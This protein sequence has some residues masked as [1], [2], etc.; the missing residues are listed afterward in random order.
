MNRKSPRSV[1]VALVEVKPL[2]GCE[3]DPLLYGGAVVRCYVAAETEKEAVGSIAADLRDM[4]FELESLDWCVDDATVEWETPNDPTA[5]SLKSEAR[6]SEEV[7]F[8]E[9]HAWPLEE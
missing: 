5:A 7:I 8:G 3:L 4:H 2:D 1:Y 9:F 6:A